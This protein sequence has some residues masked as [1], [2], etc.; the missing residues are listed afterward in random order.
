MLFMRRLPLLSVLTL[1]AASIAP[2]AYADSTT[3]QTVGP[4]G[5]VRTSPDAAPS[6]ANPV[7][8]T[9]GARQSWGGGCPTNC[10]EGDAT[11]TITL[12][13]KHDR[14]RGD[15]L[16]GPNGSDFVG[17]QVDVT[18]SPGD[19]NFDLTFE[20]DA[21]AYHPDF[22]PGP[23]P[24]NAIQFAFE[25]YAPGMESTQPSRFGAIEKLPDG[26]YRLVVKGGRFWGASDQAGSY[27][28]L[29]QSFYS[30][31]GYEAKDKG[32]LQ[33]A[34]RKGVGI[35]FGG[36]YEASVKAKITVSPSVAKRLKLKST[37][38]GSSSFPKQGHGFGYIK[39]SAAARKALKKY[40]KVVVYIETDQTTAWGETQKNRSKVTLTTKKPQDDELG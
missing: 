3:T 21:S 34:L 37:T 29:Q 2:A 25:G 12:K 23:T 9:V 19:V 32:S 33:T 15:G 24:V 16:E 20:I 27:D 38:L 28:L 4:G 40:N 13:D 26:D 8:V 6:P 18:A 7:I 10:Q 17:P 14:G 11:F 36:N 30:G 35:N 31:N 5:T 39:L 22:I 1:A